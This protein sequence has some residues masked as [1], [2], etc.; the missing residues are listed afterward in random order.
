MLLNFV[1]VG[2]LS[3]FLARRRSTDATRRDATPLYPFVVARLYFRLVFWCVYIPYRLAEKFNLL[4]RELSAVVCS[5]Q[6]KDHDV[7]KSILNDFLP[8]RYTV[9]N[10]ILID[11]FSMIVT[12]LDH[13][14]DRAKGTFF[15]RIIRTIR[16][17]RKIFSRAIRI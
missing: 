8:Q 9:T 3:P 6:G 10:L 2:D 11:E 12:S 16:K 1:N 5:L 7:K 15:A 4:Q 13:A 17:S 14:F